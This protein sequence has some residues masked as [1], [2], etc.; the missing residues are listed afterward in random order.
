MTDSWLPLRKVARLHRP[1]ERWS[2]LGISPGVGEEVWVCLGEGC[3]CTARP[4]HEGLH[5]HAGILEEAVGLP[6]HSVSQLHQL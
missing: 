5:L 4:S 1:H 6:L 2:K 3:D